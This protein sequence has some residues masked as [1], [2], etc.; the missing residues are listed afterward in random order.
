MG[1]VPATVRKALE[2]ERALAIGEIGLDYHY[3]FSPRG[4]QRDVF[5]AQLELASECSLPVV[6]HTREATD[7][8][9]AILRDAGP[10][11]RGVFHCFTGDVPMAQRV[12]ESGFH[13]SL[14]GIVTFPKAGELREV[15]R[16]VPE[17]RLLLETDSPY[18]A[19]VPFG[20][21]ATS[22]PWWAMFSTPSRSSAASLQRI[23]RRRRSATSPPF[24]VQLFPFKRLSALTL[25]AKLHYSGATGTENGTPL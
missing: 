22:R 10:G 21:N 3:D 23:W 8:T 20:G 11:L 18:L 14:A 16:M 1:E 4:V 7:D 19:P 2:G 13:L 25:R 9:F 24:L 17:D 6:I 12:L 15:A 5:A